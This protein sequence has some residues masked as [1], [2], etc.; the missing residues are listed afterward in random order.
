MC[1]MVLEEKA[2]RKWLTLKQ[3]ACD[4]NKEFNLSITS[5]KNLLKAKKCFYTGLPLSTNTLTVDRVDNSKGYIKGNVVACH[6]KVNLLKT[7]LEI[8]QLNRLVV[9]LNKKTI[10]E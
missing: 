4:R 6:I 1:D 5:I 3:S 7:D 2:A 10:G 8:K 9:K